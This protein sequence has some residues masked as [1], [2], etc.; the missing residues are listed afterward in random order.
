MRMPMIRDMPRN[1]GLRWIAAMVLTMA[2]TFA[3]AQAP[4][5]SGKSMQTA[6]AS[7]SVSGEE[8]KIQRFDL[9]ALTNLPQHR[10]HAEAHGKVVDCSGPNLID[11]LE[12]V[13]APSG[14]ALRGKNLA[15]YVRVSAAD[16][17]RVV[18]ALAELDPAS[19]N[20]V[21]IVTAACEGHP[22]E[23]KDG[24]FRLVVPGEK[25]PARWVRQ[26]TAINLLRTP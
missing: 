8:G 19:R 4:A 7:I 22:L 5:D 1:T 18:F 15:L 26:V 2:C 16:G 13:S 24:P 12:A 6:A 25:R 11:L 23:A 9:A 17:Y 20:E 10:V 21:P 14:E 3:C